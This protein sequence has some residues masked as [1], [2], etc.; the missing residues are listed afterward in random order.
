MTVAVM[1]SHTE[2]GWREILQARS[3][4][5]GEDGPPR[6]AQPPRETKKYGGLPWPNHRRH[7]RPQSLRTFPRPKQTRSKLNRQ[8]P[9]L[10][11]TGGAASCLLRLPLA[12][13][14]AHRHGCAISRRHAG[15]SAGSIRRGGRMHRGLESGRTERASRRS[16]APAGRELPS[17]GLQRKEYPRLRIAKNLRFSIDRPAGLRTIPTIM[18]F[19]AGVT[20]PDAR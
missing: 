2:A 4:V 9:V 3:V 10:R 1:H 14:R 17:G 12:H 13:S 5:A 7:S 8:R 18:R 15:E 19:F 20:H 16:E 11:M 6:F